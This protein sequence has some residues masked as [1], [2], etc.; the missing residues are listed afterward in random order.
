MTNHLTRYSKILFG[1]F[2]ICVPLITNASPLG[3]SIL[4]PLLA[5][6]IVL[7]GVCDWQPYVIARQYL[8][9]HHFSKLGIVQ[10]MRLKSSMLDLKLPST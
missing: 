4:L 8:A 7:S 2:L 3:Y 6:P 10:S 5:I 1:A 9:E